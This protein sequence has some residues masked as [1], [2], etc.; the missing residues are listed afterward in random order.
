MTTSAVRGT[1]L[2]GFALLALALRR[3][4]SLALKL[5]PGFVLAGMSLTLLGPPA[6]ADPLPPACPAG[7]TMVTSAEVQGATGALAGTMYVGFRRSAPACTLQGV[8]R[9]EILDATGQALPVTQVAAAGWKGRT[10]PAVTLGTSQVS[11]AVVPIV[12]SNFCQSP[13]PPAPYSLRV[14]LPDGQ[15]LPLNPPL[16]TPDSRGYPANASYLPRCDAPGSPSTLAV[17]P[18]EPFVPPMPHD[19]RYFAQT[20]YRIDDD[21][22]WDYFNRRGGLATFGYPVSRTFR[23][24]GFRVQLFQRR[25]VE[26]DAQGHPRLLNTLDPG[27]MPYTSFNGA[28]FPSIDSDLV[29]SAP[30]ATDAAAVLAFVKAHA[31]DQFAGMPVNFYQTFA[32]TVPYAVAFPNG[33]D[34]GLLPGLDLEMWGVPT[35]QPMV[36]PNNHDFVYLRFQRGIM[37][38]DARCN[39]TQGVL[40][41]D[42]LKAILTGEGLPADLDQ[43]A[44]SSQF[45]RQLYPISPGWVRDPSRLPD[46]DLTIAFTPG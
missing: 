23:L 26:L 46:T 45:Y 35:S 24:Q 34:P 12:W 21:T 4:P 19:E 43:E 41:A 8:P 25:I 39:C 15:V 40:L 7:N 31:P 37:H 30:S 28:T 27:L 13:T 42:Y 5:M 9:V 11:L 18:F 2:L 16:I 3:L 36:D 10:G 32:N 44:R 38:Y 14:A 1:R 17:G 6:F 22:I 33:G 20:G 29:A